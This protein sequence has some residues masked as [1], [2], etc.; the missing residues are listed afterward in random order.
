LLT[1]SSFVVTSLAES[2]PYMSTANLSKVFAPM[3]IGSSRSP[4]EDGLKK[5]Q[6]LKE[7]QM[8]RLVRK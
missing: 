6:E 7:Q 8:V 4:V 1:N 2:R 3:V 5:L